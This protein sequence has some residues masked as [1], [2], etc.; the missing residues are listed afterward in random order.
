M[1]VLA[2]SLVSCGGSAAQELIDVAK[3]AEPTRI[4]TVASYVVS[5][6]ESYN[7]YYVMT[8]EGNDSI[9][10]FEYERRATVQEQAD[11]M[12][13]TVEGKVYYNDGLY[14]YDGDRWESQAPAAINLDFNL[15]LKLF[16]SYA[17]NGNSLSAVVSGDNIALVLGS[18]LAVD[19]AVSLNIVTN[20]TYLT[21]IEVSYKTTS[22]ANVTVDTT[23]TY[24][25][26]TLEFPA[27]PA[28]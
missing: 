25:A 22:G 27:Q 11:G 3:A 18:K 8:V 7:G 15:D 21:A 16:D 2:F 19:G 6:S 9:F 5:D 17:E 4:T 14:S 10:E 20:G 24:D 28:E 26:I 13:K 1:L 12:K 23:Y